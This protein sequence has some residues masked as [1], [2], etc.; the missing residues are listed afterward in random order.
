LTDTNKSSILGILENETFVNE[1]T[2]KI[3]NEGVV[4]EMVVVDNKVVLKE[5]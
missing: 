1:D 3:K 5:V 2:I 4:K